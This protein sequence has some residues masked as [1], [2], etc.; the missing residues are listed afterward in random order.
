MKTGK[1]DNQVGKIQM[2]SECSCNPVKSA[3]LTG[4][5]HT[6]HEQQGIALIMVLWL[7]VL[8]TVIAASHAH[9]IRTETR[10]ASNHIEAGKARGLA[11]AGIYHAIMEMLVNDKALRWPANGSIHRISN[12]S[13]EVAIAVRDAR[14]LLDIN[15]ASAVLLDKVLAATELL[16][17]EQRQSLVD[18]ILDWR[19][20]DSMKH[21]NGAEDED[22]QRSGL[23]WS[24]RDDSFSSV[25]EFRYVLGMNN[26]LFERLAPY[27]TIYSGQAG[28]KL[29][30]AP[31][32]L[33]SVLTDAQGTSTA[34]GTAATDG[35]SIF[36][37]S[38]WATTTAGS[39]ASLDTVVHIAP[40][41]DQ[42]YTILSWRMP[43]RSV[44][45]DPD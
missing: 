29:D 27:L 16:E 17:T 40:R 22:Y 42:V 4:T 32:W 15:K 41:S 14:G 5:I 36:H 28:I 38:A 34:V 1:M 23:K 33:V 3:L 39:S 20:R 37:I 45:A 2:K 21:I 12:E 10:L 18:A 26:T 44:T 6:Q 31:P 35:G 43:S 19:D 11:E 30:Y 13:G 7:L 8:M 25:E 9:I 24:A